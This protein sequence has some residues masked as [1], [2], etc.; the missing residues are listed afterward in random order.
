MTSRVLQPY[1][2]IQYV[3]QHVRLVVNV[4][5]VILAILMAHVWQKMS[6]TRVALIKHLN[7]VAVIVV[8]QPV[9]CQIVQTGTAII[10]ALQDVNVMLDM[11]VTS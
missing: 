1:K 3:L 8:N 5:Q 10:H 7:R 4:N 11:F 6:V 2:I 9:E